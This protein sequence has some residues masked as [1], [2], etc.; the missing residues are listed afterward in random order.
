[1]APA[2]ATLKSREVFTAFK[3][4]H[5]GTLRITAEGEEPLLVMRETPQSSEERLSPEQLK[6]IRGDFEDFQRGNHMPAR[7][8]IVKLRAR[9][10]L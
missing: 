8:A 9:H 10:A 5:A 6:Q 4:A 2:E 3:N 1:M 7:E